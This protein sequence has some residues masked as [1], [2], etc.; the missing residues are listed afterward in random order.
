V[1]GDVSV[2]SETFLVTDFVNLKI[3]PAQSYEGAHKGRVC[4][5]VF[6]EVS[7]YT[8]M[9]I[10]ICTVFLKK[11]LAKGETWLRTRAGATKKSRRDTNLVSDSCSR[12]WRA[13][14]HEYRGFGWQNQKWE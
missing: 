3:K 12:G 14:G 5:R 11:K 9:S 10:Y 2:D 4:I 8:C 1:G 6:I 7:A 13:L